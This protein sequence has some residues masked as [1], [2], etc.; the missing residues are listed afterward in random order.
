MKKRQERNDGNLVIQGGKVVRIRD[1]IGRRRRDHKSIE[2]R[3]RK[4]GET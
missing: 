3:K 1:R 4:K 2:K